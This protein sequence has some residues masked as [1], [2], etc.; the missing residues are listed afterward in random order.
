M[1][2]AELAEEIYRL[3]LQMR[4]AHGKHS[5]TDFEASMRG[6]SG[7]LS[8]VYGVS[9]RTIRD[10]WNR[11]TWAFATVHLWG[12]ENYGAGPGVPTCPLMQARLLIVGFFFR[13]G[14]LT[15]ATFQIDSGLVHRQPGRPKGSRDRKPR[16]KRQYAS[17]I[18][19]P[20][21]KFSIP[22]Q[23]QPHQQ[24]IQPGEVND[25]EDSWIRPETKDSDLGRDESSYHNQC[26]GNSTQYE[27]AGPS[28]PVADPFHEDWPYW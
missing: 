19:G 9:A 14:L 7:P 5:S 26:Q 10:I 27:W 17:Y 2:T 4:A 21:K 15:Y 6:K 24:T 11:N 28:F 16:I 22:I 13:F 1:L 12:K 20:E 18:T 8:K 23:A 3:K 25:N